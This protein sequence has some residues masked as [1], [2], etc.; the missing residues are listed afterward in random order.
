VIRAWVEALEV[1]VRCGVSEEERALP[2]RLLVDLEYSYAAGGEDDLAG[3]VDYGALIEGV[4]RT[5]EGEEFKLLETAVERVGLYALRTFPGIADLE[6]AVTK[7]SVPV[8]RSVGRA[9]VRRE[10]FRAR[11]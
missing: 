7:V 2:Q 4:A 6:V 3:V 10:F 9:T 11:R 1:Y 8:A 5:L